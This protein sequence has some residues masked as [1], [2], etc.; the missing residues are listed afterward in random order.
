MNKKNNTVLFIVEGEVAEPT[1]LNGIL[2]D[3]GLCD[4]QIYSYKTN[5]YSLYHKLRDTFDDDEEY[6]LFTFI[7][8][9]ELEKNNP[10]NI[11]KFKRKQI[12][13]IYLFFDLD[14]HNDERTE[15]NIAKVK[16]LIECFNDENGLGKL[17]ISYPMIE[18]LTMYHQLQDSKINFYLFRADTNETKTG[19]K[20][21]AICNTNPRSHHLRQTFSTHDIEWIKKY[22]LLLCKH[23]YQLKEI[24]SST[25]KS[26]V[27][28]SKTLEKQNES[29]QKNNKLII[30][31][32]SIAEF[33]LDYI[34]SEEFPELD[35][36]IENIII[37]L[38]NDD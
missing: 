8:D 1:I 17:Y 20:F 16:E 23:I 32:S 13:E 22:H 31:F 4:N 29:Y 33:L 34:N 10:D 24:D 38:W 12:S 30:V 19:T 25:Y 18:A 7:V 6:D 11:I 21:K 35:N 15:E 2:S 37:D 27:T 28:T 3:I 36:S 26:F 5:I 14:A 9:L